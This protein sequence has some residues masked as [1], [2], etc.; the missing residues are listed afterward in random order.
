MATKHLFIPV[1]F[2]WHKHEEIDPLYKNYQVDG[3]VDAE[4]DQII[5]KEGIQL[6]RREDD[7][8]VY[9]KFK[10]PSEGMRNGKVIEYSAPDV[11][12]STGEVVDGIPQ[13]VKFEGKVGNGS[14][15]V[16]KLEVYTGGK[17]VGTRWVGSRIDKLVEYDPDNKAPRPLSE[18]YPF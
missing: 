3:Y 9:Y 2:Y 16:L 6:K 15:G 14:K 1:T 10:R 11:R 8:G 7:K 5:Q 4:W 12:L 18:E 17:G 13:T